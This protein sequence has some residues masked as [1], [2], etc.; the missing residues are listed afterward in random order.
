MSM[1]TKLLNI[2][3]VILLG[4]FIFVL[5]LTPARADKVNVIEQSVL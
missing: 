3:K 5:G 4:L 2:G 1:L